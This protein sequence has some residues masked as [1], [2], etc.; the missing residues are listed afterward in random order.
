M[1]KDAYCTKSLTTSGTSAQYPTGAIV[2]GGSAVDEIDL[3]K[4]PLNGDLYLW[5]AATLSSGAGNLAVV[6]ESDDNTGFSSAQDRVV[7]PTL[8]GGTDTYREVP[9]GY[10]PERYGRIRLT[11][12]GTAVFAVSAGIGL[13]ASTNRVA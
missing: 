1:P 12:T 11:P 5:I 3:S 6:L 7:M 2:S 4:L 9:L 8:T 10:V 13:G